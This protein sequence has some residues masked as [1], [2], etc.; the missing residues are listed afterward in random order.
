MTKRILAAAFVAVVLCGCTAGPYRNLA[1]M[2]AARHSSAF[3][4]NLTAQLVT[5]GIVSEGEAPR[6]EVLLDGQLLPPREC[7]YLTDQNVS[8]IDIKGGKGVIQL[9]LYGQT[10]SAD[11]LVLTGD[12]RGSSRSTVYVEASADGQT[13]VSIGSGILRPARDQKFIKHF[14]EWVVPLGSPAH[15][16]FFRFK[17]DSPG[18]YLTSVSDAFFFKED[19]VYDLMTN[20]NFVSCWKSA[21]ARD[22]WISVDLGGPST[23]DKVEFQWLN[24]PVSGTVQV[25]T[26]GK[27]WRNVASISGEPS[28]SFK[29]VKADYVR[30][31]LDSTANG[32]PFALSE[33]EVWGKGG[34]KLETGEWELCRAGTDD[35]IPAT[36]PGTVLGSYVDIGAVPDPNFADNQL[37]ISDSYFRSD[38]LYR[39]NFTASFDSP[40]QFLTFDGINWKA[41]VSLNGTYLGLIQGAFN[42]ETFDV[43]GILR[44]GKNLLEV[45]VRHNEHYGTIKEAT[46]YTPDKNGGIL[47]ADNPTM[48]ATI[49][50]DWIP[51]VRGRNMGIYDDVRLTYTGN[52][53][54]DDPFVR[55]ELPLPDTTRA[56]VFASV[57]LTNHSSQPVSGTVRGSF[58]P[59]EFSSQEAL[60]AG[61][62]RLVSFSP[63]VFENP[64]LWWPNGY[65]KPNLYPVEFSFEADGKVSHSVAFS[66]G[67]RQMEYTMEPYQASG[68]SPFIGRNNNQRL[69]LYINGRRFVG[70][71]GNWGFP[72]H[73]L[74]YGEKEYDIAVGYHKAM[75]FTMIRDWVG[76]IGS[77]AFYDACD[78]HGIM[79]WQ[80][81]WLAN[82]WDGPDPDNPEMFN[83][84][85]EKYVK[86]IRNHPSIGLYVGRNEGYPPEEI[87]SFLVSMVAREHPGLY[88][89][90]HSAADGVSGGGPY[91][92]K[93]VKEYFSMFGNDKFHSERGMPAV[94]NYENMVRAFG[95]ENVEPFNS[96]AHPNQIYGL[97]DYTL[98]RLEG[99]AQE[100]ESFNELLVKG[101]GEPASARTFAYLAQWINYDGYRAMFESRAAHRRGLLLWMSHPAW[102]SMV[103]QTYDYYFEPTGAYFGCKKA[104][105]PVHI[106]MNPLTG[107]VEAVN[108]RAGKLC[109]LTAS[110]KVLNMD[111]S[112]AWSGSASLDLPEDSTASCFPLE[113]P[114]DISPVYFVKLELT[115][116]AGEVLSRNFYWQGREEGNYQALWDLPQ[117]Q[118]KKSFDKVSD[119]SY[120]AT[121][122]NTGSVPALML[123]L[124]LVDSRTGEL[125][126]PVLYSDNYFF[127]MPGESRSIDIR[128]SSGNPA[129]EIEGLNID[130]VFSVK[131][132]EA[133]LEGI[134]DRTAGLFH[135]YEAVAGPDTPAPS[136]Y[137]PFYISHYGRHGSRRQ[138]GG[139]GTDAY[140]FMNMA[141]SLGLLTAEGKELLADLE[142]LYNAHVG[143]DGQLTVRGGKEHQGIAE[144]MYK[145]FKPVFK[146]RKAVH[147]QSSDI[148]RCIISMANFTSAL[149]GAAPKL[150]F[151][152]I[153][154]KKYF[155][156]LCHNYYPKGSLADRQNA[157]EDSV[158]H[159]L[160]NPERWMKA[161]FTD[162]AKASELMGG[163]P[164][165]L[166]SYFFYILADCQD[167]CY[168]V[169]GLDLYK[170]F[171]KDELLG[172]AKHSNE[173][174]YSSMG[175]STEWGDYT[176]WAEKWLI[177]DFIDR[178][179]KAIAA[180]DVAA[181]LRFGHD[182][183]LLPLAGLIGLDGVSRRYKVGDAWK[184]GYYL[185][186]N[187]CMGSNLQMVF[188]K[189]SKEELLVKFL[190]NE[191]ERTIARCYIP[192]VT[193]PHPVSGPYYSWP[194]VRKYLVAISQDKTFGK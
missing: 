19:K 122:E 1:H 114:S 9:N 186:E 63:A 76:M 49:G 21:G 104:C 149:K 193:V 50:W 170:Y 162:G 92:A 102:P 78:R 26:D 137:K 112:I 80:D 158:A 143:M 12:V 4:Y 29:K 54:V 131:D 30:V 181:D 175:N 144:R 121:V 180:G 172:M 34:A 65:G 115:D 106:F 156:L 113:V 165:E 163:D 111:G 60:K 82:P 95:E 46:P 69:S 100:A 148:Q 154:G 141:D 25:S 36:V 125:I 52:V 81:F 68:Y 188:Y 8:S 62:S 28:V 153:T 32:Q 101:F 130:D 145:R 118:L 146:G 132:Y 57:V 128:V 173:H 67:V 167:L 117:A 13:W 90:P 33:L 116:A 15:Y 190:Y 126:L 108:Y 151:D 140:L 42:A 174:L 97:H 133:A 93:P 89:I 192:G 24:A 40:R 41:D 91:N 72:E 94:M 6:T 73:L 134:I 142:V 185:W 110:A 166:A 152:F 23:I 105:E 70:F 168:E 35:W 160:I 136:G 178:A 119:G 5:D 77:K 37:Y 161:F 10:V 147:C 58:G 99:S 139:G 191:R 124:K 43:T 66:S 135:S 120:V 64:K 127:L 150:E 176:L 107:G 17:I 48:H 27:A 38:F 71:G 88:Y 45:T 183:A 83:A 7:G 169:D 59:V 61:E 14:T 75:N 171:T 179:D 3:D 20:Q 84:I 182:S 177:E 159:A 155:D 157:Q 22:E 138:I 123:R 184:N 194:D 2:R 86:R 164:V 98:G 87:D 18:A 109:G 55:T 85:A 44:K 96:L 189:N 47:G 31:L 74:K 103:W 16:S 56:T 51:T 53:T 11:L 187:I 39:R 129:L 79:I